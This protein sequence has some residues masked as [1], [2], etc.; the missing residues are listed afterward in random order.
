MEKVLKVSIITPSYNQGQFIQR[1]I[2]SVLNQDYPN[3]EHIVM[4]GGSTDNTL[5]IL[6]KYDDRLVWKSENDKGQSHGINKGFKMATGEILGWLNSDDM[7]RP[8]AISKVVEFFKNNPDVG[9]IYGDCDII[10][11]DD[12]HT[13][14]YHAESFDFTRLLN[15]GDIIPQQ[16]SFFRRKVLETVGFLD[17]NLHYAMDLDFFIRIGK[18]YKIRY[19]N[20]LLA[21]FR[22]YGRQKTHDKSLLQYRKAC[23][24]QNRVRRRHGA[25]LL[26]KKRIQQ[27]YNLMRKLFLN[28]ILPKN[29]PQRNALKKLVGR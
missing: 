8:G 24:E 26:I 23:K 22:V 16:S 5:E 2:L 12:N 28:Y 6:K 7:Y 14:Y 18:R 1:M 19:L 15:D 20:D 11:E 29:S 3:I 4:D 25:N 27:N 17:I 13:R 9:M 10:D 21:S